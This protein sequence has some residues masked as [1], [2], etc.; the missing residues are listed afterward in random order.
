MARNARASKPAEFDL[1]RPDVVT[2]GTTTLLLLVLV[3]LEVDLPVVFVV[4]VADAAG[5]DKNTGCSC[6]DVFVDV[7]GDVAGL[8]PVLPPKVGMNVV[9]LLSATEQGE[10]PSNDRAA[11]KRSSK[12]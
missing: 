2:G 12:L 5:E 8:I 1:G 4:V 6:D 7:V 11:S 3:L 9:P 10:I